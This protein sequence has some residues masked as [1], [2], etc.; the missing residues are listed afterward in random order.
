[1]AIFI[2][3]KFPNAWLRPTHHAWFPRTL[4]SRTTNKSSDYVRDFQ[5][6]KWNIAVLSH[7]GCQF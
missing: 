5:I 2:S 6:S 4:L 1:M 3:K 7:S